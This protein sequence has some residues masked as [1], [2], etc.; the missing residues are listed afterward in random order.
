MGFT[1]AE[2]QKNA[3]ATALRSKV[4]V[5]TGGPGVGKTTIVNS[6][7]KIIMAKG[8]RVALAAPTGRAAKRLSEST[9]TEAKTIH[10]LLE[11]NPISGGFAR[12]KELPLECDLLVIDETSMVDVPLMSQLLNA[13]PDKA[14]IIIVGDVDQ[15]P[16]VGPGQ[17]RL[18]HCLSS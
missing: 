16:S 8:T 14:A 11:F 9:G 10:R 4:L 3:V 6:I 13:V 15:L 1:L 5:I 12:C 2:S 17:G 18:S 7:L